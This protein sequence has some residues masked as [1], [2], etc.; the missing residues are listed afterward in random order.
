MPVHSSLV[1]APTWNWHLPMRFD[2]RDHT[3]KPAFRRPSVHSPMRHSVPSPWHPGPSFDRSTV[4]PPGTIVRAC[5]QAPERPLAHAF[6]RSLAL[7]PG[8]V[9]RPFTHPGPYV[10]ACLHSDARP[11]KSSFR[12]FEPS[13][14]R[15]VERLAL[16]PLRR[17]SDTRDHVYAKEGDKSADRGLRLNRSRQQ[18]RSTAYTTLIQLRGLRRI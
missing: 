7:A 13:L 17:L 1:F 11:S 3:S 4:H 5:V 10:R 15:S 16:G 9:V 2:T 12:A 14:R 6:F 8:T 18:G